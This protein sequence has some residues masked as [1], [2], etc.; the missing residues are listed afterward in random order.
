[1]AETEKLNLGDESAPK[2]SSKGILFAILGSVLITLALVFG[3]LYFL[4]IFPPKDKP[5]DPHAKEATA[6]EEEAHPPQPM[7]YLALKPAFAANFK[8]NP[9]I[10]V[11]QVELTVA[12]TD[13][14]V[15]DAITKHDPMIRNNLLLLL[16]AQDP[17]ALK[18]AE[19]K[20]AFRNQ[21][22]EALKKVVIEQTDKKVGVDEVYF[23]GFV[24]Q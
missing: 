17:A 14:A 5:A 13:Q 10:R 2:K 15:L 11:V 19:G 21:I 6:H 12:S 22:K 9:E 3:A 7:L 24:M 18:T 1:M 20:E 16:S 8:G 4:G 23:T